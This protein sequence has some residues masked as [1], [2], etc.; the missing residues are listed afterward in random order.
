MFL[1]EDRLYIPV[2]ASSPLPQIKEHVSFQSC[3]LSSPLFSHKKTC[4]GNHSSDPANHPGS[5]NH[6]PTC[7]YDALDSDHLYSSNEQHCVVSL[8]FKP[9]QNKGS[10]SIKINILHL[11]NSQ[12][13]VTINYMIAKYKSWWIPLNNTTVNSLHQVVGS[14]ISKWCVIFAVLISE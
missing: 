10:V 12:A 9:K 14:Y 2:S 8:S 7:S 1:F 3:S 5:S 6:S 4:L 13:F 11:K